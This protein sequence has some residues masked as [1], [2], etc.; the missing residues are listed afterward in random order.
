[1]ERPKFERIV[2]FGKRHVREVL[3]STTLLAA[4]VVLACK[5]EEVEVRK[6]GSPTPTPT[7]VAERTATPTPTPLVETPTPTSEPTPTPEVLST[8]AALAELDAIENMTRNPDQ[9]L[10]AQLNIDPGIAENRI[11]EIMEG[12][13]LDYDGVLDETDIP[14]LNH[15]RQSLRENNRTQAKEQLVK[16]FDSFHPFASTDDVQVTEEELN[17]IDPDHVFAPLPVG[18]GRTVTA[19]Y[20]EAAVRVIQLFYKL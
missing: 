9:N 6:V 1:M 8:E 15:V 20:K 5:G 17:V 2:K 19:V 16:V 4:T 3:A 12:F 7:P 13:D 14:G 11:F 10:I 18:L